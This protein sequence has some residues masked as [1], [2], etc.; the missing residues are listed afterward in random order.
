V[1]LFLRNQIKGECDVSRRNIRMKE[2]LRSVMAEVDALDLPDGAHFALIA[3]RM[4]FDHG[5]AESMI[6][7][8]PE[9]YG[10]SEA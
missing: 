9:F 2:K 1:A 6:A 3:E 8:D 7:G 5:D 10:Y 4:G